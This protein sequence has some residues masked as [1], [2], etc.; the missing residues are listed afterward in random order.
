MTVLFEQRVLFVV[1]FSQRKRPGISGGNA[2]LQ[3]QSM[4]KQLNNIHTI[5]NE[6]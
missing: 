1:G 2:S 6:H 5:T 3:K 4:Y